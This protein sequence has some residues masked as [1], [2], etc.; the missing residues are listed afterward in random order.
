MFPGH[1]AIFF[2]FLNKLTQFSQPPHEMAA[3]PTLQMKKLKTK[4]VISNLVTQVVSDKRGSE[5][6]H[7]P[8]R[9]H[10]FHPMADSFPILYVSFLP[11]GSPGYL[12][13]ASLRETLSSASFRVSVF[14]FL[15]PALR[16]CQPSS[17]CTQPLCFPYVRLYAFSP[18]CQWNTALVAGHNIFLWLSFH[19]SSSRKTSAA[20]AALTPIV[21]SAFGRV[22]A[23]SDKLL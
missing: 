7:S 17:F 9:P 11:V 16:F 18:S 21:R 23:D 4:R 22:T 5:W 6:E 2:L 20:A 1:Q 12:T 3:I 13:D 14:A 19:H 10:M 15:P 8:S